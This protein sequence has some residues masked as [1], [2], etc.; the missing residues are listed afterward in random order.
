MDSSACKLRLFMIKLYNYEE[1]LYYNVENLVRYRFKKNLEL[2]KAV[3]EWINNRSFAIKL[4]G[5]IS[6]WDTSCITSMKLLFYKEYEDLD[7]NENIN[8]WDVSNVEDMSWMFCRCVRFN[9]PLKKWNVSKV[10]TMEG[11]FEGCH[12]LD[13]NI[14]MWNVSQIKNMRS[15]FKECAKFNKRLDKWSVVNVK[16][17]DHMFNGCLR[18]NQ[19]LE[20]WD[21][22]NVIDMSKMFYSCLKFRIPLSKWNIGDTTNIS[23]MFTHCK[24]RPI[25]YPKKFGRYYSTMN[26]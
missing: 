3:N 19:N 26:K 7:F 24:L 6:L 9:K 15:M 13:I 14:N 25:G 21:I 1:S 11:M 2:K 20:K 22:R 18:F 16:R 4:Y 8:S 10:K 5:K 12:S 23:Y 17:M